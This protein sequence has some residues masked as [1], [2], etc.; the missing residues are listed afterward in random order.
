[1]EQ[2]SIDRGFTCEAIMWVGEQLI[3]HDKRHAFRY[4]VRNQ[5]GNVIGFINADR[6]RQHPGV[7]WERSVLHDGKIE[8]LV[9]KYAT[10]QEAL[11]TF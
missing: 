11:A 10:V 5:R 3:P 2:F 8:E 4:E 1:M 9:G 7:A 6:A